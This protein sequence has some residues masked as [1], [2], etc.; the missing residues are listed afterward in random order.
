MSAIQESK[1]SE[2]KDVRLKYKS[3]H[4]PQSPN[5][6]LPRCFF[7]GMFVGSRGTGKTFAIVKLLK[8]YEKNK[9]LDP[10]GNVVGQRVILFSPTHQSNPV[11]TALRYLDDD[12]VIPKFS[13]AKL[14]EVIDD[15]KEERKNTL[16]YQRKLDIYKR[17]IKVKSLDKLSHED[18]IEFE[19]MDYEPPEEPRYPNGCAVFL[20]LDDLV[21]S[22][23]FKQTG[24][25]DV[26]NMI[27]LNRH[28]GINVLVATQNLKAIPKSIRSNTSLYVLFRFANKR[29]ILE[30]MYEEVSNVL[31]QKA[32]E[33]L[34][35]HA[36]ADEHD[37]MVIDF[38][39]PK[40]ERF[41][42]NWD[43]VLSQK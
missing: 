42:R 14:R 8:H 13:E 6:H 16:E 29:V 11:F 7:M 5:P 12:D 22:S 10:Q 30:D 36:T 24:K 1:L 27:I 32:F 25:S 4:Y 15:I 3:L 38:T 34:Y 35:D 23:A 21:G 19:R 39:L 28:I 20:I 31:S 26:T 37:S 40:E 17:C 43:V 41:K 33:E 9:L 2:L 18:L